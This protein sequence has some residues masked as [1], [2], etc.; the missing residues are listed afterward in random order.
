MFVVCKRVTSEYRPR[1]P[2]RSP[3]RPQHQIKLK[4]PTPMLQTDDRYRWMRHWTMLMSVFQNICSYSKHLLKWCSSSIYWIFK[5]HRCISSMV[6]R[7]SCF[8]ASEKFWSKRGISRRPLLKRVVAKCLC[9]IHVFV[10]SRNR[11]TKWKTP[12][13]RGNELLW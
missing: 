13:K 6:Y 7:T 1:Q 2:V 3:S 4:Q 10:L 5:F 11:T 9:P 8:I 12:R